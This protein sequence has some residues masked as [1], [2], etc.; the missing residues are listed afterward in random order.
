MAGYAAIA[1]RLARWLQQAS[2]RRALNRLCG[3]TLMLM[4]AALLLAGNGAH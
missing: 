1:A 4:G 2:A 3:G